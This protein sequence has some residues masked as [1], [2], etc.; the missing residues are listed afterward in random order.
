M[1]TT[2]LQTAPMLMTHLYPPLVTGDS[3]EDAIELLCNVSR[4]E[5]LTSDFYDFKWF[6]DGTSLDLSYY[7]TI[8]VSSLCII[9][10]KVY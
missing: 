10:N 3:G 7:K 4:T 6:K 2:L 5:N 9:Q 8:M 1:S